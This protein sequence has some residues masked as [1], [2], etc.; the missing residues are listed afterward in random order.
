MDHRGGLGTGLALDDHAL[1]CQLASLRSSVAFAFRSSVTET[2]Y[3][4][5]CIRFLVSTLTGVSG[6][7][8]QL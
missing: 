4:N 5:G 6:F 2:Y 3:K 8:S 1:E 7:L